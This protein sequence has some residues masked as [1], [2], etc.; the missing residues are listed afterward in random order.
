[1]KKQ[2]W[3]K[4]DGYNDYFISNLGNLKSIK[5]GK[6]RY[7]ALTEDKDGYLKAKLYKNGKC[8]D[9]YIHRLVAKTFIENPNNYKIVNHI[10]ES[11]QNNK[12]ENLEWCTS[13]YN[14]N[15]GTR[16]FKNNRK[17]YI[18]EALNLLKKVENKDEKLSKAINLLEKIK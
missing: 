15:Y 2:I 14:N 18:C 7:M 5:F 3:K 1:M 16:Y 6:D 11:K 12:V 4:I 13:K 17:K 8:K 10:D 9:A